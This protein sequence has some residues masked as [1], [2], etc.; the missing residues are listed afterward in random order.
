MAKRKKP[1]KQRKWMKIN[2]KNHLK[3]FM[4]FFAIV[5]ALAGMMI[6]LMYI[7]QTSGEKYQRIV[8]AQHGYNSV[9]IP[10][11]RG[12]ITDCRGIV[13]ATS[14]DVY[15]LILD[16]YVLTSKEEYL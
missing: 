3:M 11:R 5:V 7:E 15:N 9:T 10:Y 1:K 16:C 4:V 6:R 13:L 2:R 12:D 8:L 14:V